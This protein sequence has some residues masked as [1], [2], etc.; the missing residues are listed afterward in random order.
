[1]LLHVYY[2]ETHGNGS[3]WSNYFHHDWVETSIYYEAS[4]TGL[5]YRLTSSFYNRGD[6]NKR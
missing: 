3:S 5:F 2:E 4:P 6:P 1:M